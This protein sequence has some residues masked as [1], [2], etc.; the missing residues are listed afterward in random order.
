[1]KIVQ[2]LYSVDDKWKNVRISSGKSNDS[3][4]RMVRVPGGKSMMQLQIGGTVSS[5]SSVHPTKET[6]LNIQNSSQI[7]NNAIERPTMSDLQDMFTPT[8]IMSDE[9]TSSSNVVQEPEE[10]RTSSETVVN[11]GIYVTRLS[12]EKSADSSA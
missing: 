4:L 6:W 12:V 1:M 10:A 11:K 2:T 5:T 3:Q 8:E 7:S 9:G